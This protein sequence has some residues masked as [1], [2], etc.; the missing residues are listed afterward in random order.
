M[1]A[2][3]VVRDRISFP[4]SSLIS[5]PVDSKRFRKAMAG[6]ADRLPLRFSA[7]RPLT[8][9]VG[10][11]LGIFVGHAPRAKTP[12]AT[13]ACRITQGENNRSYNSHYGRRRLATQ[14]NVPSPN[15]I[16]AAGSGIV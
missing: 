4:R 15:S 9:P 6:A 8:I 14:A 2:T 13:A 12:R 5:R 7:K 3:T 10:G 11:L 1:S 16:A